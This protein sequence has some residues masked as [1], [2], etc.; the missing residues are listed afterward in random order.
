MEETNFD[1]R[2]CV[3]NKGLYCEADGDCF[4]GEKHGNKEVQT[5]LSVR[6]IYKMAIEKW[7]REEQTNLAIEEMAEL[8]QAINKTRR[9]PNS[10]KARDNI[11]EEIADVS[12]MLEQ[13]ILIYDCQE[14]VEDWKER[15]VSRILEHLMKY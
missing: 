1:C 13:L 9:Y 5:E 11:A 7:G 8:M 6:D 10:L 12:V 4:E 3:F 14:N 15:K 2:H